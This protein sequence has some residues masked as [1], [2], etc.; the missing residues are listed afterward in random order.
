MKEP[1]AK[2]GHVMHI[3]DI[4]VKPGAGDEF[5]ELF[6]EYDYSDDN[7]MHKSDAQIKDGV[8][9]RHAEDPDRF[10]LIGEWRSIEEHAAIRKLVA[11][12][13]VKPKYRSLIVG[14]FAPF[15]VKVVA[16]TPPDIL[17]R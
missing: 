1:L 2:E 13:P 16:A 4:R 9:C 6:R 17:N 14:D 7:P 5:I 8:L 3:Y 10:Y 12:R 11:A 15:Y